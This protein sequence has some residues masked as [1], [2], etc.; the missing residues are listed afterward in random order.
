MLTIVWDVDD[1]LNNLMATWLEEAW[2]PAHPGCTVACGDLTANPPHQVL[3]VEKSEYLASLDEFRASSRAHSL[4]PHPVILDW[5]AVHGRYFRHMALTARPL[6]SAGSAADWVFRHFGSYI[7]SYGVVPSRLDPALPLYDR[8]KADFL[9]WFPAADYFVDD[10][11]EN[12]DAV[13]KMGVNGIVF[14]QPWNRAART[15][16]DTLNLLT[17]QVVN[18]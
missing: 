11:E 3:G 15:V 2:R 13:R 8:D 12:V 7:R 1:V 17:R 5:L 16:E 10:S 14:P 18:R 6:A 4:T 9:R